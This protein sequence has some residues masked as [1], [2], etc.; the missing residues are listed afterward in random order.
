MTG[1]SIAR[2]ARTAPR[3]PRS[4]A[5]GLSL[6]ASE[7]S[8]VAASTRASSSSSRNTISMSVPGPSQSSRSST[9]TIGSPGSAHAA[10]MSLTH[11]RR[12]GASVERRSV[13][14]I[15]ARRSGT[16]S[17]RTPAGAESESTSAEAE[18]AS[19]SR[20]SDTPA[21][22]V[23]SPKSTSRFRLARQRRTASL[24]AL[25]T[26]RRAGWEKRSTNHAPPRGAASSFPAHMRAIISAAYVDPW[27]SEARIRS[28]AST[29]EGVAAS[30]SRRWKT[31]RRW[32]S[33]LP[34]SRRTGL[35]APQRC[36]RA[37]AAG[38]ETASYLAR[39][40][41]ASAA[42][43]RSSGV[44]SR[45]FSL[46]AS[47]SGGASAGSPSPS[48]SAPGGTG[49]GFARSRSRTAS[50]MPC[51]ASFATDAGSDMSTPRSS[52]RASSAGANASAG[53][54]SPSAGMGT[55][56]RMRRATDGKFTSPSG[57]SGSSSNVGSAGGA[58]S[59][60]SEAMSRRRGASPL[61][62]ARRRRARAAVPRIAD[63]NGQQTPDAASRVG[64]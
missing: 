21:S 55:G 50:T 46:S 61:A 35:G 4:S 58:S 15:V 7:R 60:E 17:V 57:T 18:P 3:R 23:Q 62:I 24:A 41:S 36:A 2:S 56:A 43:L 25:P 8:V 48:P 53:R 22:S 52:L 12:A 28:A 13:A 38:R 6:V 16:P 64:S 39:I 26:T 14:K 31:T 10:P 5:A 49:G 33:A 42:A 9:R 27:A 32:R 51:S 47:A 40:A 20:S 34:R 29:M 54:S 63:V 37:R 44:G 11:S 30:G 19:A 1:G 59:S 45:A